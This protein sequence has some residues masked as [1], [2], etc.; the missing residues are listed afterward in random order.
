MIWPLLQ[1]DPV[2]QGLYPVDQPSGSSAAPL[3]QRP[4]SHRV[5]GGW[6]ILQLSL[7]LFGRNRCRRPE[8]AE[9]VNLVE[10]GV[11]LAPFLRLGKL[12][13][14][15]GQLFLAMIPAIQFL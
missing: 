9:Q 3:D 13:L 7:N 11:F 14:E 8:W 4:L 6:L 1:L 5:E 15:L 12:P 10:D 2:A